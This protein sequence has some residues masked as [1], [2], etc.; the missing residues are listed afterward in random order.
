MC[1]MI[2]TTG[3]ATVIDEIRNAI[4]QCGRTRY[5]ISKATGISQS[6]LSR[7][8]SQKAGLSIESLEALAENLGLEIVVRPKG[9]RKGK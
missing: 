9:P 5:A 2:G 1:S 3:M 8:M 6:Q 4:K 7:L